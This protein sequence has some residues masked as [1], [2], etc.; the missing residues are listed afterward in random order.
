MVREDEGDKATP[1]K[2]PGGRQVAL[3][4]EAARDA[5]LSALARTGNISLA[6]KVAR[7]HRQTAYEWRQTEPLFETAWQD[8]LK[9]ATDVL[10]QEA[11][12]R[13]V[14]GTKKP[15][16]QGGQH[17]GDIQEFSDTLLIFL[18]KG[19]APE[20]YR[21]RMLTEQQHS[22]NVR[23]AIEYVNDW[24]KYSPMVEAEHREAGGKSA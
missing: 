23:I 20:K 24:R 13:A 19:A 14:E 12:R 21:E 17:V 10:E 18:L 16:Y 15:V 2:R 6:C 9:D 5:F 11:R 22:G 7:I 4:P 1:K 3:G 8:A